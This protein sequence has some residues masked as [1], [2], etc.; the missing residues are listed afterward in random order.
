MNKEI[1]PIQNLD[2]GEEI[3]WQGKPDLLPFLFSLKFVSVN[4]IFFV[5]IAPFALWG[6]FLLTVAIFLMSSMQN[7]ASSLGILIPFC[8]IPGVFIF[9]FLAPILRYRLYKI[10]K[11]YVT[12]RRIIIEQQKNIVDANYQIY[13]FINIKEILYEEGFSDKLFRH[14]TA[15]L[16]IV[17]RQPTML[18]EQRNKL[19]SIINAQKVFELIQSVRTDISTD[20]KFPNLKRPDT[21]PGYPTS[22]N[23]IKK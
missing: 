20:I 15:T 2:Q 16:E 14:G 7:S 21:N 11:Y 1:N 19:E 18:V 9:V 12:S 5:L 23:N 3:L 13:D 4:L 6:C 8:L 22:K 17:T 10:T